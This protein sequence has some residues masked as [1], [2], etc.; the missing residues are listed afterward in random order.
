LADKTFRWQC[1]SMILVAAE[2]DKNAW[3]AVTEKCNSLSYT[4]LASLLFKLYYF[5]LVH[6]CQPNVFSANWLSA[7]RFVSEKSGK[8]CT[9]PLLQCSAPLLMQLYHKCNMFCTLVRRFWPLITA[10]SRKMLTYAVT[11]WAVPVLSSIPS[12]RVSLCKGRFPQTTQH[13]PTYATQRTQRNA[14]VGSCVALHCVSALRFVVCGNHPACMVVLHSTTV[15]CPRLL[16][17][18][19]VLFNF[20]RCTCTVFDMIVS[21]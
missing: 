17:I 18:L 2:N 8:Q 16:A 6:D 15:V 10:S 3:I 1:C 12:A 9:R 14:R 19:F 4:K 21:P 7:K 5:R 20:V 11:A 13:N